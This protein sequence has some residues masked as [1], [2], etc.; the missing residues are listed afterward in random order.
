[1]KRN[2]HCKKEEKKKKSQAKNLTFAEKSCMEV[3]SHFLQSC[4]CCAAAAEHNMQNCCRIVALIS[5]A[6]L[7][8]FVHTI[9][10]TV[11]IT[12]VHGTIVETCAAQQAIYGS[13]APYWKMNTRKLTRR[14]WN[15]AL[16]TL[17]SV[18]DTGVY[19]AFSYTTITCCTHVNGVML[20]FFQFVF[21]SGM[22]LHIETYKENTLSV[23]RRVCPA[24][25]I[26]TGIVPSK[27][28]TPNKLGMRVDRILG[29]VQAEVCTS[30]TCTLSDNLRT[31]HKLRPQKLH[32]TCP[33]HFQTQTNS[34]REMP[35]TLKKQIK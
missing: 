6:C 7:H 32:W 31:R 30:F 19:L 3:H 5:I 25:P 13:I 17:A 26:P 35:R 27:M 15:I 14:R 29:S 22:I 8:C 18:C 34:S 16:L 21:H 20:C 28:K 23:Y 33:L 4:N 1:M 2:N 10:T 9:P 12:V 24:V 11:V